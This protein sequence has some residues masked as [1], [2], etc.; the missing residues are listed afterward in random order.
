MR[1]GYCW[2]HPWRCQRPIVRYP[3]Y[4]I[5]AAPVAAAPVAVASAPCTC[6]RKTYLPNGAVLFQDICT[7][8]A[9]VNPPQQAAEG[10]QEPAP[11]Q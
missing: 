4:P 11:Q 9:A 6:L 2:R 5:A 3:V 1:P 10:P 7:N 8:E